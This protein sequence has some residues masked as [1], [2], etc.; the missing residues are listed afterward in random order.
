MQRRARI[1]QGLLLTALLA[2]CDRAAPS[3]SDPKIIGGREAGSHPFM[4][5]L[6][7]EGGQTAYCGASFIARDVVLTAAHC[8][9][10]AAARMRVSV[11]LRNNSEH[12][13]STTIPVAAVRIHPDYLK[14]NDDVMGHDI[15][16][17][18][19]GAYDDDAL[20]ADV[21][22]I[23]LNTQANLPETAAGGFATVIGWGNT[24][25]YGSLFEDGL[26]EVDVSIVSLA[27]CRDAYGDMIA[28]QI[29]AGDFAQGGKDSCQ[30]DSGGPLIAKN[31][32][33]NDVL[34]G[35]VSWGD[36]CAL[37][38][39]PGVYTRVS[40][41]KSWIDAETTRFRATQPTTTTAADVTDFVASHCYA[42]LEKTTED[43]EGGNKLTVTNRFLPTAAF[44]SGNGPGGSSST[45][46]MTPCHFALGGDGD[47]FKV[48]LQGTTETSL[49]LVAKRTAPAA[50]WTAPAAP[51]TKALMLCEDAAL[52][53]LYDPQGRESFVFIANTYYDFASPFSGTIRNDAVIK[54]CKVHGFKL[55]FIEQTGLLG[56][57]HIGEITSP[58]VGGT[59]RFSLEKW[60][61]G[62]AG[63]LALSFEK[64]DATKG[65]LTLE[66]T[67]ANDLHT[68]ELA[69]EF[70][71]TIID[72]AGKQHAPTNGSDGMKHW[73][74]ST[75]TDAEGTIR[76]G[77]TA[78]MKYATTTGLPATTANRCMI[79]KRPVEVTVQ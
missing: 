63:Q 59:K 11:G 7:D 9:K 38:G 31:G 57:Q 8:V 52:K 72:A 79:N 46:T 22:P 44:T 5:G 65:K 61:G 37:S 73:K 55:R 35:V 75:P 45:F 48:E 41:F 3:I 15:A 67:L 13:N 50:S 43:S 27:S 17:L 69:C 76:A 18:F 47:A 32:A 14:I 30:G 56:K 42:K 74:F 40:A 4:A 64:E 21:Q 26:R 51:S 62:A 77:E 68:W 58:V 49:K 20:P 25:S 60:S 71:F 66:N 33:G 29:C 28:S 54:E 12:G 39:K 19:L 10:D 16:L 78:S 2:A 1:A 24:T 23:A 6:I 36:G 70:G 34:V 53:L